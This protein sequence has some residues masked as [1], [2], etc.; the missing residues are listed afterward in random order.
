[1]RTQYPTNEAQRLAALQSYGL[2]ARPYIHE[3][4]ELARLAALFCAT[5]IAI[6]SLIDHKYQY[7]KAAFGSQLKT[8][9]R[10]YSCCAQT[11]VERELVVY[12]QASLERSFGHH[13]LV[14]QGFQFYAG[15][16]IINQQGFALGC[17]AVIDHQPRQLSSQQRE[18]LQLIAQQLSHQFEL[19]RQV[20]QLTALPHDVFH[21]SIA[22]DPQVPSKTPLIAKM[23]QQLHKPL[24]TI[25]TDSQLLAD[26]L[27]E[28]G[29]AELEPTAHHIQET[30]A[31]L[32]ALIDDMIDL[33]KIEHGQLDVHYEEVCLGPLIDQLNVIVAPLMVRN[34]NT[35]HV[36]IGTRQRIFWSDNRLVRQILVNVVGNAAKFT[37]AGSVRIEVSEEQRNGQHYLAFHVIDTGIGMTPEQQVQL[38]QE[39]PRLGKSLGSQPSTGLGLAIS[40]RLA[41]LLGGDIT[42]SSNPGIGSHF[43]LY[44]P[45][46]ATPQI[47]QPQAA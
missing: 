4:D 32:L 38:F 16:P 8:I 21:S 1:M 3:F 36:Q 31:Q 24:H 7:I 39:Q 10:K 35:F 13:P 43:T 37:H 12:D 5:P 42:L 44:L 41:L 47:T 2:L 6:I 34:H 25:M 30:S 33:A 15:M 28:A 11:V 18:S 20:Q 29:V 9:P 19:F 14:Q 27:I 17:I 46:K 23:S 26:Q 40:K 45:L 22:S